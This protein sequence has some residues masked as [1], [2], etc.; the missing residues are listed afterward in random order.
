MCNGGYDDY[1][2]EWNAGDSVGPE[3]NKSEEKGM[4][5]CVIVGQKA[6]V[7]QQRHT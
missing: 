1:N 6:T 4:S 2:R 5:L 3:K 7:L